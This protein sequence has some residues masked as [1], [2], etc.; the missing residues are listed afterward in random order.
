MTVWGRRGLRD[1]A[2]SEGHGDCSK[3]L[4]F[5]AKK[6]AEAAGLANP[7]FQPPGHFTGL[8]VTHTNCTRRWTKPFG[9]LRAN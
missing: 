3:G 5:G 8:L 2:G 4:G 9:I 1:Q 7:A 6:E